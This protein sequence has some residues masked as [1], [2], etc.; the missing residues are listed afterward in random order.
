MVSALLAGSSVAGLLMKCML[1]AS[2]PELLGALQ[3]LEQG[4]G[5]WA[6]EKMVRGLSHL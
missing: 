4:V 6:A 1:E 3:H 2:S 5:H